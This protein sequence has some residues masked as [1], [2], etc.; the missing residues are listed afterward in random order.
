[1][2]TSALLAQHCLELRFRDG[3]HNLFLDPPHPDIAAKIGTIRGVA[4]AS[5]DGEGESMTLE[6]ASGAWVAP[7]V[8]ALLRYEGVMV[9]AV[10]DLDAPAPQFENDPV[11]TRLP[12]SEG[13]LA[14]LRHLRGFAA[15]QELA[16]SGS[17]GFGG[18]VISLAEAFR[19]VEF[20]RLTPG[21]LPALVEAIESVV[22]RVGAGGPGR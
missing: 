19:S 3:S 22:E 9:T 12:T 17:G 14:M 8:E 21:R 5:T 13:V 2:P 6:V 18:L 10:E 4:T 11:L 15:I 7:A 1:M 16:R 20:Y